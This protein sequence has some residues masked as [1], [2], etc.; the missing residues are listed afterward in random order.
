[1]QF[2]NLNRQFR[3][4]DWTRELTSTLI[5]LYEGRPELYNVKH[6]FYSNKHARAEA[7]HHIVA[8]LQTK[9][10]DI[11]VADVKSKLT[12]LR[13]HYTHELKKIRQSGRSGAGAED[14]YK[15]TV[16]WFEQT[17]FLEPYIKCRKSESNLPSR[18]PPKQLSP[19]EVRFRIFSVS[20]IAIC[21]TFTSRWSSI[22]IHSSKRMSAAMIHHVLMFHVLPPLKV[23]P[24]KRGT[25][26]KRR[27]QTNRFYCRQHLYSKQKVRA[28]KRKTS[29]PIF[30][31]S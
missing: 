21:S 30:A 25:A 11:S 20:F 27:F 8:S 4:A 10:K 12:T 23:S 7:F 1:M 19:E 26:N 24:R 5:S 28:K 16:W 3:V 14:I 15:P 17:K 6:H 29:H 13:T 2:N 31:I 9:Q 22:F 18:S